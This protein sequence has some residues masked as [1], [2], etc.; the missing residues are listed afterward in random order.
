MTTPRLCPDCHLEPV[1]GLC[2]DCFRV[3]SCRPILGLL[4]GAVLTLAALYLFWCAT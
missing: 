4:A 3:M 2:P 1:D